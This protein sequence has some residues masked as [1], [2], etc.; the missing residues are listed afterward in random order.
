MRVLEE[1]K[2]HDCGLEH[3]NEDMRA[4]IGG[5]VIGTDHQVH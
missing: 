3:V 4:C 1:Y 5:V 2:Y